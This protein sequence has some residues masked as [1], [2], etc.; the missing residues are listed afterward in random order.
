MADP[1][2]ALRQAAVP[3]DPR[4]EFAAALRRQIAHELGLGDRRAGASA[5]SAALAG[6]R[7]APR[8]VTRVHEGYHAVTAYLAVPDAR[9]AIDWYTDI[10]GASL[11]GEPIVMDD[12]RI[13]HAE[14]RVGDTVLMLADEFPELDVLAPPARGG[15][16][17]SF[18]AYVPDVDETYQRAV[19]AGAVVER[20]P[21]DQFHGSRAGW[22]R[23]PF[24]HRWSLSTPLPDGPPTRALSPVSGELGYY[25]FYVPDVDRAAAFYGALFGWSFEEASPTPDGVHRGRH[26]NNTTLP[27]GVN[28]DPSFASPNLHYRVADLQAAVAVV[29]EIGGEVVSVADDAAGPSAVCRDDQGVEFQLWQPAPGYA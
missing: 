16:S 15:T 25:T 5:S 24:G 3:L 4:P 2:D 8:P 19:A 18:V 1:F 27:L 7:A 29:R 26:V 20:P 12:G 21:S 23:D 11:R 14:I 10:L 13:G 6:A 17:V 28:D 9:A 22:L